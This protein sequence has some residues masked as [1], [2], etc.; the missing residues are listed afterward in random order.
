MKLINLIQNSNQLF[1]QAFNLKRTFTH[2]DSKNNKDIFHL[3]KKKQNLL[4]LM[5]IINNFMSVNR[6]K[7][8]NN[9]NRNRTCL[10]RMHKEQF[11]SKR[12][13]QLALFRNHLNF[14]KGKSN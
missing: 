13:N 8:K 11:E 5:L 12:I 9:S 1:Q 2:K 7:S 3:K 10:I 14:L 6:I 4:H